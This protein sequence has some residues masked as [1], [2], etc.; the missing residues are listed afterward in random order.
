MLIELWPYGLRQ[1]NLFTLMFII[2]CQYSESTNVTAETS[3]LYIILVLPIENTLEYGVL[4]TSKL[5]TKESM[6]SYPSS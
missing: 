2:D 4:C 6:G 3:S 1:N 5:P